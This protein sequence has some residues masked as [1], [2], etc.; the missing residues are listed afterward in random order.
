MGSV[1]NIVRPHVGF[2]DLFVRTGVD[3]CVAGGSVSV[4]KSSGA[5]L[6]VAENFLDPTFRGVFLRNNIDDLKSGGGLL[7]T[8]REFYGD[9]VLVTESQR[10]RVTYL[11]TGAYIDVTHVSDQSREKVEQR[12]KGRQYKYV[13]F[14]EGTGFTWDTFVTIATRNRGKGGVQPQICITTNPKRKHW[15]RKMVD[16][17]I[18]DDGVAIEERCGVVRYFFVNGTTVDDVVWGDSKEEVYERCRPMIDRLVRGAFGK[19]VKVPEDAWRGLIKSFTYYQGHMAENTENMEANIGYLGSVAMAGGSNAL[20]YIEGNWNADEDDDKDD[21]VPYSVADSVFLND[22]QRNGDMWVTCDLADTGTDNFVAL[23]W[24]GL[25]VIDICI[26][27]QSTPRANAERLKTF[28]NRHGVSER[29]I[30]YDAIR[31]RYIN[32]YLPEAIPFESY[33]APFG[34][35]SLQYQKLKD[36]CYAKLIRLI[37]GGYISF[38]SAVGSQIYTHQKL[39]EEITVRAEFAEEVRVVRFVD[40]QNGRLRLMTKKEM[41]KNLGRGR[42]MDLLD[43]CAMRMYPLVSLMDGTELESGRA[44][45]EPYRSEYADH[46]PDTIDIYDEHEWY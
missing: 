29:H 41:N 17:Y 2:Q 35:L 14:D 21:V 1:T 16:W 8:F 4:G 13:Y 27:S 19:R 15:L 37:K 36:E 33:R 20:N 32:D 30:I 39:H 5:V 3:V 18:G 31:G 9:A 38:S 28:A 46:S 12:F 11:D 6:A 44:D 23:A 40:A 42:S 26:V 24:D 45:A 43:P 34:L 22:E 10:P 25:H 7:D